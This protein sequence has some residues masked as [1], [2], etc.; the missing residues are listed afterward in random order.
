MTESSVGW[1]LL[2]ATVCLFST[3]HWIGGSILCLFLWA[4]P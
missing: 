2:I 3:G 4:R 1:A